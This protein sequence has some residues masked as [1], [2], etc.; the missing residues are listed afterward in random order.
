MTNDTG[1][2]LGQLAGLREWQ[3]SNSGDNSERLGRM[4]RRLPDAIA[5]LTPRQR[6]MIQLQIWRKSDRH[7]DRPAAGRQQIHGVP[8]SAPGAADAIQPPALYLIKHGPS[9]DK[10]QGVYYNLPS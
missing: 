2:D 7:P 3:R 4:R 8:L 5:E 9:L 1:F 6:Q 10:A